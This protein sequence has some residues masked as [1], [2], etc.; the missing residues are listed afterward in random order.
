MSKLIAVRI[1]DELAAKLEGRKTT[2]TVVAALEAF[3]NLK[4]AWAVSGAGLPPTIDA[5]V[6]PNCGGMTTPLAYSRPA[7][8]PTCKCLM[9]KPPSKTAS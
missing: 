5:K 9:C 3:F 8:D 6:V 2:E 7:H 1:P 4:P